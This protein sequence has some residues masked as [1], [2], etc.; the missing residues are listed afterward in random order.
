[1]EFFAEKSAILKK[2]L[3]AYVCFI[4]PYF[5]DRMRKVRSR[6][7]VPRL[8][9]FPVEM[10]PFAA[11]RCEEALFDEKMVKNKKRRL[12]FA[13]FV[14]IEPCY[15]KENVLYYGINIFSIFWRLYKNEGSIE[16]VRKTVLH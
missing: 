14:K 16:K 7:L 15:R 3:K 6:R 8:L 11:D 12:I 5:G 1:M 9:Y 2:E 13:N 4:R 10:L